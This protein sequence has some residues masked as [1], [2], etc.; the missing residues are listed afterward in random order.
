M[1]P[2]LD[3]NDCLDDGI[4]RQCLRCG[5]LPPS[6]HMDG[7]R[8]YPEASV[9]PGYS[10]RIP[11]VIEASQALAWSKR[12]GLTPLYGPRRLP[13]VAAEAITILDG[14]VNAT[15]RQ[16]VRERREEAAR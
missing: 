11:E 14:H 6:Q 10:T 2:F 9:C 12:G 13:S 8:P 7:M 4:S 16:M 1:V 15:E 3:C 5:F